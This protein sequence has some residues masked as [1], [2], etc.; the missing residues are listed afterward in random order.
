MSAVLVVFFL[1][2]P[3]PLM[4]GVT[5]GLVLTNGMWKKDVV[6]QFQ[7]CLKRPHVFLLI[8]LNLCHHS[9]KSMSRL[10]LWSK[11]DEKCVEQ[12]T[13]GSQSYGRKKSLSSQPFKSPRINDDCFKS[14]GF[15]VGGYTT[16][17]QYLTNTLNKTHLYMWCFTRCEK[18]L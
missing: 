12:T 3:E 18:K 11:E 5:K 7:A 2:G 1:L 14:S 8:T 17:A 15:E 10:V 6:C 16:L 13:L 9:E 4:F